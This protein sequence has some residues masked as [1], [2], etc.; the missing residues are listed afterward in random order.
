M[1]Y[2]AGQQPF[3]VVSE[4]GYGY[5]CTFLNVTAAATQVDRPHPIDELLQSAVP[6]LLQGLTD[7]DR[8]VP[9]AIAVFLMEPCT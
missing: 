4:S 9:Y 3:E 6:E 7:S 5:L 8:S 1:A 2:S